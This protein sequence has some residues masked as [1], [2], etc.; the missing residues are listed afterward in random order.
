MTG[1]SLMGALLI[2]LAGGVHCV[3]MCSGIAGALRFATPPAHSHWPY[4]LSYNAGRILSYTL[5]GAVAGFIGQLSVQGLPGAFPVLKVISALLLL[6]MAAYLGRWWLGL[7]RLEQAGGFIW[8]HLQPISK[9]FIPFRHPV[10]ALPYGM[11]WGWLPCGLVYSALSWA[12][13]SGSS[14]SGALVMLCFGLGTLPALLASSLGAAW[15]ATSLQ[16]PWVRQSVAIFLALYALFLLGS[17]FMAQS[18][19][20]PT[21]HH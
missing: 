13:V 14:A 3:G 21:H 5:F 12:M 7:R 20:L 2:G 9:R 16:R 15:L 6:A 19:M 1:I 10:A 17:V 8:K 11:I 4:T 18:G